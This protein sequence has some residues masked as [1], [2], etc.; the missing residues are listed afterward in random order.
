[1]DTKSQDLGSRH[2]YAER[3]TMKLAISNIAWPLQSDEAMAKIIIG[4]GFSGIEAA[5]TKIWASPVDAADEDII[6]YRKFWHER[7]I[8][9]VAAQ[10]LL[11]GH[12]ELTVFDSPEI[13]DK[14]IA[15]IDGIS[16]V[17]GLLGADA[18]VFGSPKNRIT[19]PCMPEEKIWEIA[20][21]FF[22]AIADNAQKHGTTIVI[23]ANP[24]VYGGNFITRAADALKLVKTVAHPAL[25]LHLDTA[26]M[27]MADDNADEII[28]E[29]K[30]HLHHF[31][32]SEPFLEPIFSSGKVAHQ[33][34]ASSLKE[35]GYN[36]WYSVEMKQP[37][38]F[39][40]EIIGEILDKV[41]DI[42]GR[43]E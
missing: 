26:C 7:G 24:A 3:Q 23:E 29:G 42:Y 9:I 10:A 16:R 8:S 18:L 4:S 11:F 22:A 17:C 27:T 31:H 36:G 28:K 32:I 33:Q 34:I 13:T 38:N 41:R 12:P 6:S 21:K 14:T 35:I 37:A 43:I 39:S 20:V 15:Y 19:P 5:P 30:Q 40:P 25:R 2:H 1:M